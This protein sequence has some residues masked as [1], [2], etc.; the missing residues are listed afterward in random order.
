[1]G[2]TREEYISYET[3]K[4]YIFFADQYIVC[5]FAIQLHGLFVIYTKTKMIASHPIM[6]LP[7]ATKTR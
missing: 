4:N 3:L 1:M 6:A 5:N 2:A 7:A